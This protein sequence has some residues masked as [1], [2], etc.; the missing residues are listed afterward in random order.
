MYH[1]VPSAII[2][3]DG[4][5]GWYLLAD[6]PGPRAD[7]RRR[8][9]A[10]D[11]M[12]NRIEAEWEILRP[13]LDPAAEVDSPSLNPAYHIEGDWWQGYL[14]DIV[15]S[16]EGRR[17]RQSTVRRVLCC[18]MDSPAYKAVLQRASEPGAP[19]M[20]RWSGRSRWTFREEEVKRISVLADRRQ[21][22]L[23]NAQTMQDLEEEAIR[24]EAL[25][26]RAQD[27]LREWAKDEWVGAESTGRQPVD[28]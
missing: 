23:V 22:R 15:G 16:V 8:T 26:K 25:A 12:A 3:P 20:D 11:Q 10:S 2:A 27:R 6:L 7:R 19:I 28:Q 5:S 24:A 18:Y 1:E 4:Y 9:I 13:R 17:G 21:R 14:L